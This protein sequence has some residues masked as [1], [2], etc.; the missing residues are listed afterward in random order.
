[1]QRSCPAKTVGPPTSTC[2]YRRAWSRRSSDISVG[3]PQA[4]AC[5][6]TPCHRAIGGEDSMTP[7]GQ[8]GLKHQRD[9]GC[10]TGNGRLSYL[11]GETQELSAAIAMRTTNAVHARG[12]H[13]F[14][15]MWTP[16]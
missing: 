16:L 4:A 6:E 1:M 9:T 8:S 13:V 12:G 3:H 2:R 10:P 15:F 7:A 11:L 5:A 14:G